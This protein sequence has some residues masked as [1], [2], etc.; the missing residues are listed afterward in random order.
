MDGRLLGA[1]WNEDGRNIDLDDDVA[2]LLPL[3]WLNADGR[4]IMIV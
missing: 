4:N 1:N 3:F 2:S